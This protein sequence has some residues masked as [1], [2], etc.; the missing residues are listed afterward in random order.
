VLE[1]GREGDAWVRRCSC[2]RGRRVA[3]QADARGARDE[4]RAAR[5]AGARPA[6]RADGEARPARRREGALRTASRE[7]GA[8]S[9]FPG[10]LRLRARPGAK[11]LTARAP[12]ATLRARLGARDRQPQ[13]GSPAARVLGA[14]EAGSPR[15]LRRERP[16]CAPRSGIGDALP[17]EPGERPPPGAP[18]GGLVADG[19]PWARVHIPE[20]LRTRLRPGARA[21]VRV[22][23]YP[24]PFEGRLRSVSHE[25][26]FTPY[27]ALT[28]RD[29]S[30]LSYLA[31]V[32][33]T[34]PPPSSC[35]PAFR[36][37]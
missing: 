8:P 22:D 24:E 36:S 32:D 16:K 11:E 10:G 31:E 5:R 9:S 2:A 13:R 3:A 26:A 37:R 27:F 33:V 23:G 1:N 17:F 34:S 35:P 28:Q 18:R 19:P 25:P 30:R 6:P 12:H 15:E 21:R 7:R 14:A 20:P 29:R 4:A